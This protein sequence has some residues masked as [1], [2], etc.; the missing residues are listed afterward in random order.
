MQLT[1]IVEFGYRG[2]LWVELL[3]RHD[4]WLPGS[5]GAGEKVE[6]LGMPH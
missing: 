5:V 6:I 4:E 3:T 2:I 1:S